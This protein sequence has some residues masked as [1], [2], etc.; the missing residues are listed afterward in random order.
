[1]EADISFDVTVR[2][3]ERAEEIEEGEIA[4]SEEEME[5]HADIIEL[6]EDYQNACEVNRTRNI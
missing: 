2:I 3:K 6:L 1:L 5:I 4:Q